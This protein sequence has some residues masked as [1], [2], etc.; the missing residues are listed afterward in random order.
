MPRLAWIIL[1]AIP[2]QVQTPGRTHILPQEEARRLSLEVPG[3]H[4]RAQEQHVCCTRIGHW[5]WAGIMLDTSHGLSH[6]FLMTPWRGGGSWS[7]Y[8]A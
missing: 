1:E 4:T 3:G 5:P 7:H 2:A 8:T 6:S